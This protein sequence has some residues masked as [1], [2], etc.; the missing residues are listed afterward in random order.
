MDVLGIGSGDFLRV[1]SRSHRSGP[2]AAL[3]REN[4]E[5][6]EDAERGGGNGEEVDGGDHCRVVLQECPPGLGR[7]LPP[8]GY[9]PRHGGLGHIETEFEHLAVDAGRT[10]ERVLV[11]HAPDEVAD[12]VRG[13]RPSPISTLPPPIE[14]ESLTVPSDDRLGANDGERFAPVAPDAK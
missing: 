10:P 5:D 8:A 13:T 4:E 14:A 9:V 12:L 7:R 6:I 1:V 2:P 11:S 3:V